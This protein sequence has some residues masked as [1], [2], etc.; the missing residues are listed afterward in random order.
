MRSLF[1]LATALALTLCV[2]GPACADEAASL[3]QEL[4]ALNNKIEQIDADITAAAT[5]GSAEIKDAS[6]AYAAA[7]AANTAAGQ[8]LKQRSQELATRRQQLD[9]ERAATEQSCRKTSATPQEY[10]ATLAQCEKARQTYGQHAD[11]YRTDE[12]HLADDVAAYHSAT[13]KLQ[14]QYK[15]VEQKRQDVLARQA[16]L[17]DMRQQALNQFNEIRDRLSAPPSGPNSLSPPTLQ[18]SPK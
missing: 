8:E 14:A 9:T 12:Q 3:R 5:R 17:R 16:S 13:Q 7:M 15:D 18:S 11:A 6:D 10:E 4:A 1:R 2:A